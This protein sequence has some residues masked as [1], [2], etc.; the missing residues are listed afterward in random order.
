MVCVTLVFLVSAGL[1]LD[2]LG[3]YSTTDEAYWMQRS[4]RFG[5]ALARGDFASTLRAGHPGVTVT[6]LGVLGIGPERLARYLPERYTQLEVLEVAPGYLETFDGA[7]RA[8]ALAA[9]ALVALAVAL[10][11]PLLGRGPAL[12]GGAILTLDPYA[13]G[14]TRILHADALLAPLM[15][16]SLLAGLLYWTRVGPSG[17]GRT[18]QASWPYLA[19]SSAA[20]GLAL[21]TKAPSGYLPLFFGLVCAGGLVGR[22]R[23]RRRS[24]SQADDLSPG[25]GRW[26]ERTGA[27]LP[28]LVWGLGAAATFVLLFPA[29]WVDPVGTVTLLIQ[30]VAVIGLQPHN[31]NFFLGQPI[32]ADPGPWYYAVALPLRFSPLVALGLALLTLPA[33]RAEPRFVSRWLLTYVVLFVLLMTLASKKF[34]RYMLPALMVLDLVA[35]VGL[36]R[37]AALL[38]KKAPPPSPL[39]IAMERGRRSSLLPLSTAVGRGLGGGASPVT[40][41][42]LVAVTQAAL[43]TSVWPYPIAYYNPLAGGPTRAEQLLMVGWGEGLEQVADFLNR[44]PDAAHLYVVTSYNHVVRP[45]FVGTTSAITPYVG[46]PPQGRPLPT[47][48]YVV[49][50][51]NAVQRRQIPPAARQAQADGP[52]AFVATVNGV[53]YAWVYQIPRSGPRPTGPL[54]PLNDSESE[55]N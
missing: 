47:P 7:R 39:P 17:R 21:L 36:W 28:L 55:E 54:P 14:M 31:G 38:A 23:G 20:G 18:G 41:F 25:I 30:F 42:T 5:A 53:P 15:T 10:A 16:V 2:Q 8:V 50:Y 9:A 26:R 37:L 48:D 52:P 11:W 22:W 27:L 40:L 32:L 46:S 13:I 34:D 35:G 24:G 45:R 3:L 51:V 4:V 12:I 33:P 49:L 1:R 29:M 43:L 44:L 6:W 19:L